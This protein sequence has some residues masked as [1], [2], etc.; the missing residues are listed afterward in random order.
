M[1]DGWDIER[2]GVRV[3]AG[4]MPAVFEGMLLGRLSWRPAISRRMSVRVMMPHGLRSS[5]VT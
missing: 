4:W 1:P 5:E 2:R 3:G